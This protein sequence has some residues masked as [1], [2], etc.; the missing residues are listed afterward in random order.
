MTDFPALEL[1]IA[2]MMAIHFCSGRAAWIVREA[3]ELGSEAVVVP[4][5][6]GASHCATEGVVIAEAVRTELGLPVV[7]IEVPP[8]AD[9]MFPTLAGRLEALVETVLGNR[10][11]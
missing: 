3:R 11:A 9:A 2:E 4:R 10:R 7:E 8:L 1:L 5:I 6:P